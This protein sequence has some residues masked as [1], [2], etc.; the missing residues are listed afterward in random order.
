MV[1][2]N[3]STKSH[4]SNLQITPD[5]IEQFH[6]QGYVILK[7]VLTPEQVERIVDR[8]DPLFATQF[9]TGIY[10]DEWYGRPGLS[11]PNAT[12]QMT[13]IWR[14][15]RTL[16]RFTLSPEIARINAT[17][18][19]WSAARYSF[20]GC[21][22]KPPHAPPVSF[23]CNSSFTASLNPSS[24]ITCWIALS[25]ATAEAGT[26]E[27]VPG[28]HRWTDP[29]KIRFLHAPREDYRTH[30]WKAAEAAGVSHP[31]IL[32]I[33]LSPGSAICFHGNLWHGSNRNQTV[34]KT[35]HSLSISHLHSETKFRPI[36]D[37]GYIFSSY[38]RIGEPDMEESYF[39]ILWSKDG[40]RTPF[41]EEYCGN[42]LAE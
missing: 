40:Y 39:P 33:E 28:S 14:C 24:V 36:S 10:P 15:D 9:E 26:L 2:Q 37:Q 22:I 7:D 31:A 17:L 13:G 11:Q 8:F 29:D 18:M 32:P 23:H 41:L 3:L 34:D 4:L 19:G 30:L 35:R 21:W 25:Y 5:Q 20:D 27:I 1:M 12:R 16:A 38:R 42:A 6:H